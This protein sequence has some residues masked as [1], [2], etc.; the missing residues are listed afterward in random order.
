MTDFRFVFRELEMCSGVW[1]EGETRQGLKV[2]TF[3]DSHLKTSEK[4][5]KLQNNFS[6]ALSIMKTLQSLSAFPII[7]DV[8]TLSSINKLFISSNG[9]ASSFVI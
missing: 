4:I 6:T 2:E 8:F 3:E 5:R 7:P 9:N 1:W